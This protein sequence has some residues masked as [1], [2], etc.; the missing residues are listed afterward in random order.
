MRQS[1][2]V[3]SVIAMALTISAALIFQSSVSAQGVPPSGQ[4][5]NP[6]TPTP[7]PSI[8][9]AVGQIQT[10]T[11][12]TTDDVKALDVN[13]AEQ[14]AGQVKQ[15]VQGLEDNAKSLEDGAK[16]LLSNPFGK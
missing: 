11:G 16:G 14:D 5:T 7:S 13:K 6:P 8:E 10:D 3:M 4:G 12:K 1:P 9:G 2:V 15:D